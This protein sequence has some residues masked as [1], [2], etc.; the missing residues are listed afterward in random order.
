MHKNARTGA[1]PK[2]LFSGLLKCAACG[3]NYI[4]AGPGSY[5]CATNINRGPYVC[6]NAVR[7]A[8]AV[9]EDRLL[10]AIKRDLFSDEGLALFERET[11]R[12]LAEAQ[13]DRS[14]GYSQDRARLVEVEKEIANIMPAIRAGIIT[15]TTKSA[16]E[17]AEAERARLSAEVGGPVLLARS[18]T[19]LPHARE[20]YRALVDDLS[21]TLRDHVGAARIRYRLSAARSNCTRPT[22]ASW[23]RSLPAII[24]GCWR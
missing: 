23:K 16:L 10:E 2:Y 11:S 15:P 7:V 21:D 19:R 22:T 3:A 6:P 5:G 14:R 9:L 12:L 20:V 18:A 1:G 8:R 4:I 13:A 24:A 17:G